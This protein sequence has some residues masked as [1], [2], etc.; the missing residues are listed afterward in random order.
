MLFDA[1]Y[2]AVALCFNTKDD[3]ELVLLLSITSHDRFLHFNGSFEIAVDL[4]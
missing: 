4:D 2:V 3:V 1:L